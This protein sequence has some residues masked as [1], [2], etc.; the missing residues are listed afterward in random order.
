MS[1]GTLKFPDP[2]TL[3]QSSKG[4]AEKKDKDGKKSLI[5]F[6]QT[7]DASGTS[8]Q[9]QVGPGKDGSL[10]HPEIGSL[11]GPVHIKIARHETPQG[12]DKTS[13]STY[14]IVADH[15]DIDLTTKPGTITA[16]GHVTVDADSDGT[17]ANWQDINKFV[18]QV[19][20][21]YEPLAFETYGL[22]GKPIIATAK[23]PKG[24][25]K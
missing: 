10:N 6:D 8:G 14:A 20:E 17:V 25:S 12:S 15:V 9:M 11:D 22:P 21:T 16:T 2:W 3:N 24:G 23:K 1:Q 13:T 4:T 18:L 5:A 7:V 19:S